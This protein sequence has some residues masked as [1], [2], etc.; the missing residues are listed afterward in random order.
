MIKTINIISF[1]IFAKHKNVFLLAMKNEMGI[2][3]RRRKQE[4]E[5]V[6]QRP[7]QGQDDSEDIGEQTHHTNKETNN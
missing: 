1:R 5:Q 2:D 4:Q 3:M 6:R 7:G